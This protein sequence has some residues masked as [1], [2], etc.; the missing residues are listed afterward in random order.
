MTKTEELKKV[1]EL[2]YNYL[3]C[4]RSILD[5]DYREVC[6]RFEQMIG[7]LSREAEKEAEEK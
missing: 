5:I 7:I 2:Y 4:D 1:K 3:T 6:K